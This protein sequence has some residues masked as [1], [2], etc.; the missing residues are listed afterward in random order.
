MRSEI[1]LRQVAKPRVIKNYDDLAQTVQERIK[2]FYP[3][4]FNRKLITFQNSRGISISA[5]PFETKEKYYLVRMTK[6]EALDIMESD[7]DYDENGKL[8]SH[9]FIEFQEKYS[10]AALD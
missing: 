10:E 2:L 5:L 7:E 9:R 1:F 8:K 6:A 3:Y 4:G